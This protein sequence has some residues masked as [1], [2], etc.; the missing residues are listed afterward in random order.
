M[1]VLVM[2]GE[3]DEKFSEIAV[4]MGEAIGPN[5]TLALVP[6]ASHAGHLENPDAFVGIVR[7]LEQNSL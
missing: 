5:A 1:P 6:E 7:G 4:R 2:A 3:R